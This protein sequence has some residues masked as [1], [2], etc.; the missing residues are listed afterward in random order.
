MNSAGATA[1]A[2]LLTALRA[3]QQ[4]QAWRDLV[5]PRIKEA[6]ELHSAGISDRGKTAL[7]RGEHLEA[8]HLSNELAALVPDRITSLE[9]QLTG[10]ARS[11]NSVETGV[12]DALMA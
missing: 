11:Q 8:Y 1:A 5:A 7:E 3:L 12:A 2:E 10:W 6:V 9:A 4:N